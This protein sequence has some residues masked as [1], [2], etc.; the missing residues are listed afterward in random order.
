M[1]CIKNIEYHTTKPKLPL[2]ITP[3]LVLNI[4]AAETLSC[5][6]ENTKPYSMTY[7]WYYL[8]ARVDMNEDRQ[9]H[10]WKYLYCHG[11]HLPHLDG[12]IPALLVA[13][14]GD[15]G[16]NF[17]SSIRLT[18]CFCYHPFA[19]MGFNRIGLLSMLSLQGEKSFDCVPNIVASWIAIMTCP[20]MVC[21]WT[22]REDGGIEFEIAAEEDFILRRKW[23]ALLILLLRKSA[24]EKIDSPTL[25]QITLIYFSCLEM[26]KWHETNW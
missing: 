7:H 5:D 24:Y 17:G 15:D 2:S 1:Y 23:L 4:E 22:I 18:W 26:G 6:A 12:E 19:A 16:Q 20:L 3:S 10:S 14:G 9:Q 21:I 25:V 11:P 13:F 8:E